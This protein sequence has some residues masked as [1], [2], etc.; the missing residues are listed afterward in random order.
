M[1]IVNRTAVTNNVDSI[2]IVLSAGTGRKIILIGTLEH[3]TITHVS[4]TFNGEAMTVVFD[5]VTLNSMKISAFYYDVPDALAADTYVA[6]MTL[7][8]A[9]VTKKL[10]G[11]QLA[12]RAT[13]TPA[14]AQLD[15]ATS[16]AFESTTI[17]ATVAAAA[18]DD[19]ISVL[20]NG[21]I[22]PLESPSSTE[23]TFTEQSEDANGSHRT[24]VADGEGDQTES[25]TC[26]WTSPSTGGD[27]VT[28][29]IA[30]KMASAAIPQLVGPGL[31]V[32][33]GQLVGPGGL[34]RPGA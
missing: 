25:V 22:S 11:W 24:A 31:L 19:L 26:T 14:A 27:K 12:G 34:V 32:G 7:S 6:A 10:A 18:N 4:A 8:D 21:S 17:A 28:V 33:P 15:S 2:N 1:S 16:P 3:A 30:L 29:L 9:T 20:T 5:N 13:G 23:I